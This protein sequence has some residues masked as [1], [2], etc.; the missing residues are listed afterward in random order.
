MP[1]GKTV[2]GSGQM[3]II[4]GQEQFQSDMKTAIAIGK[5]DGMHL[6]HQFLIRALIT[7]AAEQA[8]GPLKTVVF[9]FDPS[10]HV[11]FSGRKEPE[12]FTKQ[13]K[14]EAFRAMGVDLLIEFPMNDRTAQTPP[15]RFVEDVLCDG[16]QAG[17][18]IAGGD[19]SFGYRGRGDFSLL[20]SYAKEKGFLTKRIDKVM[21]KGEPVSSSRIR[22]ALSAGEMEEA[23]RMLG[24]PFSLEGE[25]LHGRHLGHTLGFPTINCNPPAGK[26]LPPFGVY[27][28]RVHTPEGLYD[29]ITN[30]G[31]KPTVGTFRR[32]GAETYLYD[33]DGDLYGKRV[34]IELLSYRRAERKFDSVDALKEQLSRD[35]ADGRRR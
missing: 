1:E 3:E 29:G 17:F 20:E 8:N 21:Y 9:T 26:L 28:S 19:L 34:R 33:F 30:I 4:S 18:V 22:S 25:V 24:A 13:E 16:L 12:I 15:E 31:V 6:G 32:A 7:G 11:F 27:L 2:V 35:I 23:N 10:P 14:R 5:F